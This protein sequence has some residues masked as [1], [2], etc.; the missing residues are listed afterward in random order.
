MSRI[1]E[2][3]LQAVDDTRDPIL[4]EGTYD[5]TNREDSENIIIAHPL[6][7]NLNQQ[8]PTKIR[9]NPDSQR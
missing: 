6:K 5:N 8:Q 2:W 7:I 4:L 1:E 9:C 3:H